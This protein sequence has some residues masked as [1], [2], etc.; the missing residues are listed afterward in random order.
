M[1]K[2]CRIARLALRTATRTEY[3]AIIHEAKVTPLQEELLRRHILDDE[4]IA[5]IAIEKHSSEQR[6][7]RQL[8]KA[9]V[10]V[11]LLLPLY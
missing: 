10:A 8:H 5:K 1:D 2:K 9:Y 7:K 11:S 6:I 4:T 3:E